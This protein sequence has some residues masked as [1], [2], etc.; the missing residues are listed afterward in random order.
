[1]THPIEH[2][3][4]L[5]TRLELVARVSQGHNRNRWN[6]DANH[7]RALVVAGM[8]GTISIDEVWKW[9]DLSAG[10]LLRDQRQIEKRRK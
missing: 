8:A 9:C 6:K 7:L 1:M 3:A 2:L 5:A 10:Q 4:A